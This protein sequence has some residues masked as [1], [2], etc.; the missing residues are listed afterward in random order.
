MIAAPDAGTGRCRAGAVR[1]F[2][3]MSM[4]PPRRYIST[5]RAIDTFTLWSG[6]FFALLLVPL[7]LANVIEVFMRYVMGQPTVWALETTVMAFGAFF[8]LGA[9]YTL[10]RGAHVRTDVLWERFS[11]RT[12]GMI[13]SV[14]Y[15]VF[16][17]PSMLLLF[18]ISFNEFV[19]AWGINEVSSYGAWRPIIWPLRAVVPATA[20]LLL[21]QCVSELLKS[22]W[23]A[24][25][26]EELVHHEKIEI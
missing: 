7:I 1:E 4:Q 14:G 10:Q 16:F 5:I 22:L 17:I 3:A 21:L 15:V 11:V 20:F 24:Y 8:M 25:A 13:D 23:A 18:Y 6:Y 9:A 19:Y 26:G 2:G 12:K